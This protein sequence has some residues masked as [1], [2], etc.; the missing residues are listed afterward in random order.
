M[1]YSGSSYCESTTIPVPGMLLAQLLGRFDPL[2][3]ERRRHA[4][5]GDEHL[6]CGC[7]RARDQ[8]VVVRGDADD[9]EIRLPR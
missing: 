5:V 1:A 2:A 3:L 9:L 4:D 7:A 8:L 6:G